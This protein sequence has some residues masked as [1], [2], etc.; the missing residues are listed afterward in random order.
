MDKE[1]NIQQEPR[2]EDL[3]LREPC[4]Q[5]NLH[6]YYR[7]EASRFIPQKISIPLFFKIEEERLRTHRWMQTA[8][9]KREEDI[10]HMEEKIKEM[11]RELSS[12]R[13]IEAI[14]KTQSES[15]NAWL[16]G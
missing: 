2:R 1:G 7:F 14:L 10:G 4:G 3:E 12:V 8:K 16:K 13:D 9:S 11:G 6:S 15:E 5:P